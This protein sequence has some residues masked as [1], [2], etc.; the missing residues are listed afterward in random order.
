MEVKPKRP[1]VC[2]EDM[3]A[4][5]AQGMTHQGLIPFTIA[6]DPD[7]RSFNAVPDASHPMADR[8]SGLSPLTLVLS[9][10]EYTFRCGEN[11]AVFVISDPAFGA[12]FRKM[13]GKAKGATKDLDVAS[14]S[15]K[16]E[17]AA[18]VPDAAA[19]ST[20]AKDAAASSTKA[21]DAAASRGGNLARGGA[22]GPLTPPKGKAA[23]KQVVFAKP[24][25]SP[26]SPS[27]LPP[28]PSPLP[29]PPPVTHAGG[30]VAE[31]SSSSLLA[32][33]DVVRRLKV[34]DEMSCGLDLHLRQE[35]ARSRSPDWAMQVKAQEAAL[36]QRIAHGQLKH[37]FRIIYLPTFVGNRGKAYKTQLL[38][39]LNGVAR[40]MWLQLPG[41]AEFVPIKTHPSIAMQNW[42]RS[43]RLER[44]LRA[45][46]PDGLNLA[47]LGQVLFGSF[48]FV[49]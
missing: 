6:L 2:E 21:K 28:P 24:A 40:P 32:M 15:S 25:A 30:A 44:I 38:Q 39:T 18:K 16:S 46:F 23:K 14:S 27:P 1:R 10:F 33:V 49:I 13:G 8:L 22:A 4:F 17:R 31:Y 36:W 43:Q 45:W 12:L 5:S 11:C 26:A 48:A 20:K 7:K 34:V 35:L 9:T 41:S 37:E 42:L 47:H 19:S 29:S 3:R